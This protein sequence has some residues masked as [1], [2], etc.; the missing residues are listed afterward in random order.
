MGGNQGN[1]GNDGDYYCD[2]NL[3]NN[4]WCPEYDT[5]EGKLLHF[6]LTACWWDFQPRPKVPKTKLPYL[7][8]LMQNKSESAKISICQQASLED[9]LFA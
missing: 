8:T 7:I 6:A 1:G 3:G 9:R 5:W 2:A 4:V